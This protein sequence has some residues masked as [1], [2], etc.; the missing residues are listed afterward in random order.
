[1][2]PLAA[3]STVHGCLIEIH[4]NGCDDLS[5][6]KQ[7]NATVASAPFTQV[8]VY[9][10]NNTDMHSNSQ[11]HLK[12]ICVLSALH[13][14]HMVRVRPL[15]ATNRFGLDIQLRWHVIMP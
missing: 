6:L 1:M 15:N 4:A 5:E 2:I 3:P 7:H 14:Y 11:T 13:A 12:S 9:Q 10:V 8:K